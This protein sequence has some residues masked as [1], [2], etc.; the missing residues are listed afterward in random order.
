MEKV[1]KEQSTAGFSSRWGLIM[2]LIGLSVG[3]G[4][5]WRFPRMTALNG[6][7]A[8]LIA[9]SIMWAVVAVP[10]MMS[11][12]A[13]GRATRHGVPGAFKD[14]LGKKFTWMGSFMVIVVVC[15]TSYY[16]VIIAWVLRYLLMAITKQYYG[17]DTLVL[18]NSVS[19]GDIITV[20]F[21]IISLSTTA[22]IVSRGIS[23]GIE[24]AM[25]VM[26][27]GIFV[28][29][30]IVVIKA[31]LTPGALEGLDYM[32]HVDA[33]Y[34]LKSTT[35]LNALTQV[36][37][38]AGPGWG[39]ILTYAVYTKAKSD[40]TLNTVTQAMGDTTV[41]LIA[42]LAIIPAL[43]A[44][45]GAE[46]ANVIMS[47]GNTGLAF[48]S[49]T[50]LFSEMSGGYIIGILFFL[51]LVFA[52]LSSNLGHFLLVSVP[53]ID[54]GKSKKKAVLY[55]FIICLI[56]G[57]PSAWNV[58]FFNN[59]DWVTGLLL[60]IGTLF[61]CFAVVRFDPKKFRELFLNT[62]ED[63]FPVGGWFEICVKFLGPICIGAMIIWW[64]VQSISWYPDTWW[65]PIAVDNLGTVIFQAALMIIA[66]IIF[67]DKVAATIKNKYFNGES[68]PEIP[69]EH[70][71]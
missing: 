30:I 70:Q 61:T 49:L 58:N 31:L 18:F 9:Y 13:I 56:W 42:S 44:S 47:S 22:F 65:K 26:A 33:A 62:P 21:F 24:K 53:F 19:N 60:L 64:S 36:A 17:V 67:N 51:A 3:T 25:K 38:S 69:P 7:G 15:I 2:T 23:E 57:L 52:G 20:I 45:Y 50:K 40:V 6:G 71:D 63:E 27:P 29:M 16:S 28:C 1:T 43:F 10:V 34:L 46:Q 41:A 32:F 8:F 59:Q 14:F 4:N 54:A 37:W 12:H 35:W 5:I 48:V 11:E 68:Y 39:L 66:S 55:M